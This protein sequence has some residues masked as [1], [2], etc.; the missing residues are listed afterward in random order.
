MCLSMCLPCACRPRLSGGSTPTSACKAY[1][2]MSRERPPARRGGSAPPI[3]TG[4]RDSIA[5][6]VDSRVEQGAT[7]RAGATTG[8]GHQY[9]RGA[10]L[11]PTHCV[12]V[13]DGTATTMPSPRFIT[14]HSARPARRSETT[15]TGRTSRPRSRKPSWPSNGRSHT[16]DG[17][18][19]TRVPFW[20]R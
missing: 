2:A 14:I 11:V 19:E 5:D 4:R 12:L 15:A 18:R 7:R 10:G 9:K 8:T 16:D 17:G 6:P 20:T 1:I 13:R 3:A